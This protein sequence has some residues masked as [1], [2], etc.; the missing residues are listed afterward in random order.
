MRIYLKKRKKKSFDPKE[1]R[2]RQK[3]G[4]IMDYIKRLK[5]TKMVDLNLIIS[6]ITLNVVVND[7]ITPVNKQRLS[8]WGERKQGTIIYGV[9]KNYFKYKTT[10][11]LKRKVWKRQTHQ[12]KAGVAIL[13]I[14]K[15]FQSNNNEGHFTR[16]WSLINR[17]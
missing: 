13:L 1:I 4:K 9:Y 15:V 10:N 5:N 11:S 2:D 16:K 12:R 6:V 8:D 7:L 3:E 17:T 14:N